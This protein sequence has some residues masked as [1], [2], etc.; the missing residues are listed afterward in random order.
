M[1]SKY[2]KIVK[3][4]SNHY[5]QLSIKYGNNVKS[6]QQSSS[7][8]RNKRYEVLLSEIKKKKNI[9]ILDFG[10]GNG[11]LYKH[12]KSK[13]FNGSY[14]GFDISSKAIELAKKSLS[15]YKKCR[16]YKKNIFEDKINENFDYVIINGVFNNQ[17]YDNWNWMKKCLILLFKK[18]KKGMFFNNL[19]YYVDY[20]QK[21]LFYIKP[22]KVFVFCKK[23][24]SMY[25]IIKND[26]QIK[27]KTIPF[28]FTTFV[29]KIK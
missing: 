16:F 1:K 6:S 11:Q 7:A 25:V 8:T 5:N 2:D 17:T 12:L 15:K 3:K 9:K 13:K 21:N 26:Y 4:L 18:V 20:K 23:Y 24:L 10:C 28:E 29:F 19:S 14:V 22:E 27:K